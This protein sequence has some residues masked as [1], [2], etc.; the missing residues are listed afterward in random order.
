MNFLRGRP[1]EGIRRTASLFVFLADQ[2][3]E[4]TYALRLGADGIQSQLTL[5]D[6]GSIERGK[7]CNE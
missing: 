4:A 6:C 3:W 5:T 2:L 7:L 1:I